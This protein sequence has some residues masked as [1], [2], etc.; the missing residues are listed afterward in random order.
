MRPLTVV[1][2]LA[3]VSFLLAAHAADAAAPR[4]DHVI[5]VVMENHSYDQVRTATYTAALIKLS[6]SFSQSFAVTHPSEPNYLA[7]W[8]AST[9]GVTDDACPPGGAPYSVANL[10]HSCEAAGLTWKSYCENLPSVGS[11]ACASSDNLYR[12][13]H[14][15]CPDFSNLTH[16]YEVPYSQLA[17]DIAA[18]KLPNLSFVV[19]NMCDDTH[20]CSVSTGDTWLSK[21]LPAMIA[22]VGPKGLVVL[23][24]DEDDDLSGNHILTVFAGPSVKANYVSSQTFNHYTL[25]RTICDVLGLSP[26]A[27][28]S[29]QTTPTDVWVS[30][31]AAVGP[32]SSEG[33]SLSEPSPN[34]FR[35]AITATLA[36]PSE[37]LVNAY[38]V[39]VLG[40]RVRSLF[41]ESRTGTSLISWDGSRDDRGRA[42][43]GL[44]FLY[45]R[46]GS[47]QVVR[48]VALTR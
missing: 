42:A 25:I 15:P 7:L 36:L 11:T 41:A 16:S 8:A 19:P 37:R 21:N 4:L 14:H 13:K 32:G 12:R 6:T 35:T 46:A 40:R 2:V 45:V 44:Y 48:R 9:M 10:G 20:D 33:L 43:P 24:W 28:A 29:S 3:A 1:S 34:P 26:F 39:D 27:N 30:G 23:T 38:V 17:L 47:E 31:V 5:V 22:A 18:G